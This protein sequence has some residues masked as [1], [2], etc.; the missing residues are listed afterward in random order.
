[1]DKDGNVYKA[2][3]EITNNGVITVKEDAV[4]WANVTNTYEKSDETTDPPVEKKTGTLM[5]G[6]SVAGREQKARD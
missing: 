1:M 5:V 3:A 4:V 6:K 2:K